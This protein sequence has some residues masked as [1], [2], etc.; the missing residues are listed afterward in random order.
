MQA[1]VG[2]LNE[3]A[4]RRHAL[5][6]ELLEKLSDPTQVDV[7][8]AHQILSHFE[9]YA[10]FGGYYCHAPNYCLLRFEDTRTSILRDLKQIIETY[11]AQNS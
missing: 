4:L 11:I 2:T 5:A 3:V 7:G 1:T 6:H 8:T 9:W 10:D